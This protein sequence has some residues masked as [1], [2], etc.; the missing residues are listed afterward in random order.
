MDVHSIW[1]YVHIVLFVYWLGADVGLYAVMIMVKNPRLSFETRKTLIMLAFYIDQFPRVTFALI[2]PVGLHLAQDLKLYPIPDWLIALAWVVGVAWSLLHLAVVKYKGTQL[3]M[4]LLRINKAYELLMGG[5]FIGVGGWSLLT[6][7]PIAA[8]WFAMKLFLF[9]LIFW[10]ILGIDT[11]FQPFTTILKMGEHG[12]T[13]DAEAEVTRQT[14]LT[15]AW[16]VLLY[17]IVLTVAF[18]GK[19]KPFW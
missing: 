8:G 12:S 10:I 3:A 2:L 5:F 9:G 19:V 18:M 7:S 15:M 4:N 14:H 17:L 13:P 6:D 16:A 11:V 1:L